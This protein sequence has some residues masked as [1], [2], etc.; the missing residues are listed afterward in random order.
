[1]YHHRHVGVTYRK[2]FP[3]PSIPCTPAWPDD[4]DIFLKNL[5]LHVW[6]D[7]TWKVESTYAGFFIVM[8]GAAVDWAAVLI[9]VICHSSAEAEISAACKA[10]KRLMFV[11]QF[12]RELGHDLVSPRLGAWS[13]AVSDQGTPLQTRNAREFFDRVFG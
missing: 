10:G 3:V 4:P 5:G 9:K 6:S 7:A 8:C 2:N 1:M 11:V 12:M 13:E